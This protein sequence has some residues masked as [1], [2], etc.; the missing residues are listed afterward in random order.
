MFLCTR[1]RSR[2]EFPGVPLDSSVLD[3]LTSHWTAR[4]YTCTRLGGF[5]ETR[6][7]ALQSRLHSHYAVDLEYMRT[8]VSTLL[9]G[10]IIFDDRRRAI[11]FLNKGDRKRQ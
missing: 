7:Q 4:L 1:R 2:S 8:R 6:V 10:L 5:A 3:V 9:T 11:H